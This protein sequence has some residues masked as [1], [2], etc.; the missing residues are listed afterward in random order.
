MR[1]C[2]VGAGFSGAVIARRLGESGYTVTVLDE[3]DH[4]AGHCH[5]ERDAN[6]GI[7]IHKFGPH[8]FHTDNQEV[9]DYVC[10]FGDMVPYTNRV[11]ANV[12]GRVYGLPI[13]LHTINQFFGQCF[14]PS[15]ARDYISSVA[16]SDIVEP[17]NFEEQ[18]LKMVGPDLYKAFFYGYTRKQ[19]GVEPAELPASILKR[20]PLRFSYDDNYYNHRFQGIP[21]DGYT[22]IVESILAADRVELRLKC[23]FEECVEEFDHVVYTGPIDRYFQYAEGRLGYRTLDFE[24]IDHHGDFQGTAVMNYCDIDVDHTRITEHR[25]FAPWEAGNYTDTVCF[26]EYSRACTPADAPFYPIHLVAEK[27]MLA[28]YVARAGEEC[29]ITFVG[30]LG[31]YSYLDM[32]VAIARALESADALLAAFGQ[33]QEP[34]VFVHSP[35]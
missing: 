32:D 7:L 18:A 34:P 10:R 30:R 21:R 5:T 1:I 9:W 25:H 31:T 33:T 14:S 19:W 16:K 29:N 17:Q 28:E 8:I 27:A 4:V 3:R 24:R 35:L 12:A 22:A 2:V 23:S 20:L 6:T 15:E 13:N 26:R 11:K